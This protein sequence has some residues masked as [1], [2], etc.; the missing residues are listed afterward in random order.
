MDAQELYRAAQ[1]AYLLELEHERYD[2]ARGGENVL[3][4]AEKRAQMDRVREATKSTYHW[5]THHTETYNQHWKEQKRPS[6]YQPFPNWPFLP[7]LLEHLEDDDER[8]KI[9]EKSRDM[10][11]TWAITGYFTLQCMLN[12]EREVIIQT[13]T[14]EKGWEVISY[15]KHLYTRQPEWLRNAFP[16]PKPLDKQPQSEFRVGSSVM[17]VIPSGVGK[18]RSYHPWGI[19]SDETAFQ[20]E[21]KVSYD[22]ARASGVR[23]IVL[24]S[25][26]SVGWF[27][28]HN[29]DAEMGDN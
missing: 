19:F 26:C 12:D 7:V 21:A 8:V 22:E 16:V 4:D 1:A 2:R 17:H 10:M 11:V 28:D 29:R 18:V 6:P 9:F 25:T 15:A 3:T 5:L 24:N 27:C 23:K 13:Q 20:P 14:D